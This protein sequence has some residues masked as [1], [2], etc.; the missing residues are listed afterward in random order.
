MSP[1]TESTLAAGDIAALAAS[2]QGDVAWPGTAGYES[3]R[4]IW[5]AAVDH[6]PALIARC[7]SIQDVQQAV[8]FAGERGMPVSVRAGGH[9]IAGHSVGEGSV[10]VDLSCGSHIDLDPGARRMN[11]RGGTTCGDVMERCAPYDLATPGAFNQH[12]GVSGLTLGGGY[13]ALT[14][15]HGLACD[16]LIEAEIITADGALRKV[17]ETEDPDLFWALRGAGAN[18]GVVTSLTF[19]LHPVTRWLAGS[20]TWPVARYR[21][22]LDF[23]R[24]Y[25]SDLPDQA[26]AYMGIR[27]TPRHEGFVFIFAFYAGPL[28]EGERV[29]APLRRFGPPMSVDIRPRS[30]VELHDN[31]VEAFPEGHHNYWRACFLPGLENGAL[32]LLS[33]YAKSTAGSDFYILIEHLGGAMARLAPD[34]TAFPHRDA[35]FG[36][37]VACKWR[38]PADADPLIRNAG[39]LH[40][41]IW[42]YSTGGMYVNYLGNSGYA[43]EPRA[44]YGANLGRLRQLKRRYDPQNVFRF[45][46]NITPLE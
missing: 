35:P 13:G 8:R 12:V 24:D 28:D 30:Y 36:L 44:T 15:L 2:L 25:V 19:N 43:D 46:V 4:R 42:P 17:S 11:T 31:N 21:Q 14:R 1:L 45:N 38:K 32:N 7:V 10:M 16:N 20:T 23:Y 22:V 29:L 41:A 40:D 5:N 6:H 34:A 3:A 33:E 9:S 26:T 37:A 39:A 18:F 27:N